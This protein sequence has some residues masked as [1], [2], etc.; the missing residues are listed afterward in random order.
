M[1]TPVNTIVVSLL[2]LV[3]GAA[4][5]LVVVESVWLLGDRTGP[6]G[7][8]D[9]ESLWDTVSGWE[10]AEWAAIA[11]YSGAIVVGAAIVVLQVLP[12]GRDHDVEIGRSESGTVVLDDRTVVP[13]LDARLA[14]R[15]W[16]RS[17]RAAIRLEG[18]RAWVRSRP[19]TVRPWDEAELAAARDD[20]QGEL[21][22]LGLE[23]VEV[24]VE[25]RAPDGR[26]ARR[27]R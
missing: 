10:P 15:E 7:P 21:E 23:A 22:R 19:R 11:A 1:R 4:A 14:D 5:A 12:R 18:T 24:E 6:V 20:L 13:V 26:R 25:P 3:L 27:V 16:V 17:G 8:I 2:I 9:Y